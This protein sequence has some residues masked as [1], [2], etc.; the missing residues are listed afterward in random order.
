MKPGWRRLLLLTYLDT[1]YSG[2]RKSFFGTLLFCEEDMMPKQPSP[3]LLVCA[4]SFLTLFML[5]LSG[6]GAQGTPTTTT[7]QTDS[8]KPVKGGT[9][10]DDIVNEPDSLIPNGGSQTFDVLV[11][12]A[13]Y[14]PL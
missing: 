9:W 8:A 4:F 2:K 13:I 3:R 11:N 12:Q 6:C 10:I 14:A 7:Q 1:R 5:V